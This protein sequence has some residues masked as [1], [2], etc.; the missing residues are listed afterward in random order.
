[1]RAWLAVWVLLAL[2]ACEAEERSA[3]AEAVEVLAPAQAYVDAVNAGDL[4]AVVGAF[5]VDGAVRDVSRMI[6]GRDA[7]RAWADAE[8][9]GG[10]L[11]VLEATPVAGGQ[12][13][14]V[15][16]A[17]AGSSGWQAHYT[18]TVDGDAIALAD[19]QYA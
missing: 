18:F 4:E 11:E 9:I 13:L 12:R 16:W 5:A 7:I 19:L 17:P 10:S 8:V 1:V 3:P 14:L 2:G 6:E 15:R